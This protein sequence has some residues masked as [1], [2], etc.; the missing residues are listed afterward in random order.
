[1]VSDTDGQFVIPP[2]TAPQKDLDEE[3]AIGSSGGK[4][5]SDSMGEFFY[6]PDRL[7]NTSY[8]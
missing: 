8:I 3:S 6:F 2:P 7:S 5:A 4:W 1:M